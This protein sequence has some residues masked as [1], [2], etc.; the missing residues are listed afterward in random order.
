MLPQGLEDDLSYIIIIK[1][2]HD[3]IGW[4]TGGN[5]M[6]F[7][8]TTVALLQSIISQDVIYSKLLFQYYSQWQQP[9]GT[10]NHVYGRCQGPISFQT[11]VTWKCLEFR[12]LG[13]M[14][15]H[16]FFK[17]I[18]CYIFGYSYEGLV[19]KM[20]RNFWNFGCQPM[21]GGG[22]CENVKFRWSV[23]PVIRPVYLTLEIWI[24]N[25]F[26]H[27]SRHSDQEILDKL[28]NLLS[29]IRPR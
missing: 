19:P 7:I 15:D 12:E 4:V 23:Q 9:W 18:K 28:L 10:T 25:A 20:I 14:Q 27:R 6:V 17:Y 1:H 8:L 2:N 16:F 24:I 3:V 26:V 22:N 5:F 29:L 13:M 11:H 21:P